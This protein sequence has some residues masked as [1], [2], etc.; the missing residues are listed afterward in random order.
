MTSREGRIF[1]VPAKYFTTSYQNE[2]TN[3]YTIAIVGSNHSI[4]RQSEKAEG[5][6]D[7]RLWSTSRLTDFQGLIEEGSTPE[8]LNTS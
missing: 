2:S 6:Q 8:S 1:T 7:E 4:G 3:I 5:K